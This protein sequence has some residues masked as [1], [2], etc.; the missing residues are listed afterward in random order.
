MAILFTN[1]QIDR[2][3]DRQTNGGQN[4][5]PAVDGLM[6]S[7]LGTSVKLFVSNMAANSHVTAFFV[8][9]LDRLQGRA[10]YMRAIRNNDAIHCKL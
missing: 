1:T 3:T 5:T 2:Q 10:T 6:P 7:T 9:I 4:I 8:R